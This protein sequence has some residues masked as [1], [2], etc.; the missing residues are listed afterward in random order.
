MGVSFMNQPR[1]LR[2][3]ARSLRQNMTAQEWILWDVLRKAQNRFY[4]RRQHPISPYIVDFYCTELKLVIEVDGGQHGGL[5]DK[6][7][8]GVLKEKGCRIL[9]FWNN[10]IDSNIDGVW[11]VISATLDDLS[12]LPRVTPTLTL[13][14]KGEGKPRNLSRFKNIPKGRA[15]P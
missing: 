5:R 14:L 15:T 8:D 2:D 10:E 11:A 3:T 12:Q 13:P 1:N 7:R 9:R 6:K 4:F